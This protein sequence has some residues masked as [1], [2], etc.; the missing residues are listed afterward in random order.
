VNEMNSSNGKKP[1]T[2]KLSPAEVEL[3]RLIAE[4][5][6]NREIARIKG[7][8]IKSC[9]NAISRVAKKL[10]IRQSPATNQRVLLAK[11]FDALHIE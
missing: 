3:L 1:P 4:G 10:D 11:E 6:S 7:V 2:L 5:L 8:K 9:E